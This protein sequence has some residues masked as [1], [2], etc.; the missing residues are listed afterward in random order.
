MLVALRIGPCGWTPAAVLTLHAMAVEL[1][2]G[3]PG[4]ELVSRR[5]LATALHDAE[6]ERSEHVQHELRPLVSL[7]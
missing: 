6:L 2:P 1:L 5:C 7:R 3:W 4:G